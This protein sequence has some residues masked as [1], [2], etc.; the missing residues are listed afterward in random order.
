MATLAL[1]DVTLYYEVEGRGPPLVLIPGLA[2]DSQSWAPVRAA[3]ARRYTLVLPDPRGAGRT[4]SDDACLSVATIAADVLALLDHLAIDPCALLGHSMGGLVAHHLAVQA[5]RRVSALVVAASGAVD[6]RTA[7]L[8]GDLAGARENGLA[9]EL[10]FRMLFQWLFKPDFFADPRRVADAASLAAGY[11]YP[12]T[13]A[14]FRAQLAA[15]TAAPPRHGASVLAPTLVLCGRLDRLI[16]PSSSRA[17]YAD[18][19]GV[20]AL[21]IDDAAH[22]LHWDQPAAFVAAVDGFLTASR[23]A[24]P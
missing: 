4:T 9:P 5:P 6:A 18:I 1:P 8:L 19:P 22:S 13:P 21:D 17:S 23:P 14:A 15:A 3:L 20:R 24:S 2:S 10:W 11:P 12:Q 16:D 7:G